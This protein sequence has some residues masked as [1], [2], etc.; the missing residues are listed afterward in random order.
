MG[1]PLNPTPPGYPEFDIKQFNELRPGLI[2]WLVLNVACLCEQSI[3]LGGLAN[4]TASMWL[5]FVM[6]SLYVVDAV[7][8]EVRMMSFSV[9][10]CLAHVISLSTQTSVLTTMDITTDGFGFML[11]IGDLAWVPFTYTLQARYLAFNP[12]RLSALSVIGIIATE[13]T[14]YYIFRSSN[15]EKDAFRS[16]RNP[17]SEC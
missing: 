4:V 14:G 17:R 5:V 13:A 7:Y 12:V 11:A 3:R 1:R 2:L 8:N 6:Q 9:S 10:S 16:G 15:W